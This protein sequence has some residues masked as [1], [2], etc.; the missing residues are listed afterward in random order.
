MKW[1]SEHV[2]ALIALELGTPGVPKVHDAVVV[3]SGYGGAVSALR[4]AESGV[5]VLVLERGDEYLPGDFPNDF[6]ELPGHVRIQRNGSGKANDNIN[7]YESGLYDF[8]FGDGVGALVGNALG[9]TSQ[10]NANVVLPPD[11]RVFSKLAGG[12]GSPLAWP[13]DLQPD[14]AGNLPQPLADAYRKAEAMLGAKPITPTT[15]GQPGETAL[16]LKTQ[17]LEELSGLIAQASFKLAEITVCLDADA[18]AS[19]SAPAWPKLDKCSA[20]GDCVTGCNYNAKKTLTTNYLPR[21]REA[22]ARMFTGVSVLS[23]QQRDGV[24][25]VRFVRTGTRKMQRDRVAI[26]VHELHARHVVLSAGTFGSTEILLRSR[27]EYALALSAQLGRHLSTNGDSLAFGYQLDQRVNGIGVGSG[28]AADGVAGVGPTITGLIQIDDAQDVTQSVL[29]EE[30]AIPGAIAGAFQEMISLSAALSQLDEG[31][32]RDEPATGTAPTDVKDWAVLAPQ[33]L[34][35]TQTLLCM[36]HDP[37]AGTMKMAPGEDSLKLFYPNEPD[38]P[39]DKLQQL[40]DGYLTQVAKQGAIPLSNPAMRPLPPGVG[41]VLSGPRISNGSFTVHP[42][43][44][45]VMAD[46]PLHG[47]VN[48]L[49]QV[50]NTRMDAQG[51]PTL[52]SGLVVLDGAI[53]P[54][55]L[56]A[57]PMLTITALA[58]RAMKT[59]APLIAAGARGDRSEPMQLKPPPAPATPPSNPHATEVGVHFT[60]AMRAPQ[61]NGQWQFAWQGERRPV[62]LL[63]HLPIEDLKQFS[64]DREHVIRLTGQDG[65]PPGDREALQ[66]RLRIDSHPYDAGKT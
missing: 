41:K 62:H 59:L 12:P 51:K 50:Y 40:H 9:G 38:G 48:S 15:F 27:N 66:A 57:N 42:L 19:E 43:G 56:G 55:A 34:S 32:F 29:I 6:G 47:V 54:T 53:V 14:G 63:L 1:L 2:E 65:T 44:G 35:H 30:G 22:G 28:N 52:H 31:R 64:G 13:A 39:M 60:E 8:R 3:G 24:W 18:P 5:A 33:S 16:P 37:C 20:C 58:E 10:I 23:V 11:P 36:G 61:E 21:A 25:I 49:G 46:N 4:L 7:G 17:R 26:E 45:C